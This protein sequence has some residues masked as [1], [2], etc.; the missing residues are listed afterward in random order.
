MKKTVFVAIMALATLPTFG[1]KVID[2]IMHND[3]LYEIVEV[4]LRSDFGIDPSKV[5]HQGVIDE[6]EARGLVRVPFG[7]AHGWAMQFNKQWL[8]WKGHSWVVGSVP[9]T[10]GPEPNM[11]YVYVLDPECKSCPYPTGCS[12]EEYKRDARSF[13]GDL[14]WIFLRRARASF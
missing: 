9:F 10:G 3:V 14:L 11:E 12:V 1:Q 5:T 6:A 8:R 13:A 7:V 4:N 2:R